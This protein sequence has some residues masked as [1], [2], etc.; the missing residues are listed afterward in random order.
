[1][2]KTLTKNPYDP[3]N[4][5]QIQ[6]RIPQTLN[7]IG[8]EMEAYDFEAEIAKN[9]VE[10]INTIHQMQQRHEEL[11]NSFSQKNYEGFK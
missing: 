3:I 7:F 11:L 4:Y 5:I 8:K 6:T 9:K 1:M 10:N 2:R